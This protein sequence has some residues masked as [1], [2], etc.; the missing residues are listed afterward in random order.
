VFPAHPKPRARRFIG[1]RR[2]ANNRKED[3]CTILTVVT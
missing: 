2:C 3:P 1:G